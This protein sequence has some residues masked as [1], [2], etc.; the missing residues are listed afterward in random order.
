MMHSLQL[1]QV[2]N[3]SAQAVFL[4]VCI[5]VPISFLLSLCCCICVQDAWE[6]DYQLAADGKTYER[7]RTCLD[8]PTYNAFSNNNR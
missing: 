2:I 3:P 1:G 7:L 4:S 6:L 5:S 8:A